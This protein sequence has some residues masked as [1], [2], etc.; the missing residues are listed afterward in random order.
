[1]YYVLQVLER[2]LR[3][4]PDQDGLELMRDTFKEVDSQMSG[5]NGIHSGC[6]AIVCFL[7]TETI[8]GVNKVINPY[9]LVR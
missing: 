1:M 2:Q 7:R 3:E 5:D 6:T 4:K 8:D 9:M